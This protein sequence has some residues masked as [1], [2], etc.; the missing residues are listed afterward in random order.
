MWSNASRKSASVW[1]RH[2][3]SLL[4]PALCIVERNEYS[5][6]C[7]LKNVAFSEP[8]TYSAMTDSK[9]EAERKRSP[10]A[11]PAFRP[12]RPPDARSP[13]K[14]N[15]TERSHSAPPQLRTQRPFRPSPVTLARS[16][17]SALQRSDRSCSVASWAPAWAPACLPVSVPLPEPGSV[18]LPE[19][20]Q[21]SILVLVQV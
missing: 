9:Q 17:A 2:C 5:E 1:R 14:R 4:A 10:L 7:F 3:N 15:T 13:G 18:L 12:F 11:L 16:T 20:V 21:V 8:I 19:S 6:C